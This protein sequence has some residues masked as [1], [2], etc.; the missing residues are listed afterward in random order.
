[1][2]VFACG[3]RR[4]AIVSVLIVLAA[5]APEKTVIPTSTFLTPAE[6]SIA[7]TV[8]ATVTATSG[9]TPSP[10]VEERCERGDDLGRMESNGQV[11]Q[12]VLHVPAAYDPAEP[13]ALVLVFHGAGI[14]AERFIDYSRFSN[15]ADRNGF[16]VVYPEGVHEVWDPSPGSRDVQ[17]I[18][19]LIDHLQKR[20]RIDP[21]RIYASGHSN[22]G[23]MVERLACE[24]ADRLA[25]IGPISGAYQSSGRCSPS[26][27]VP[28][29]AIHGTADTIIPYEGI[30]GWAAGWAARNDC[31]ARPEEIPH[32]VLIH[33]TKWSGCAEGADVILYTIRDLG[34]DW[35]HDLIDMGQTIWEFFEAHPR[36]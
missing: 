24:L 19:D 32:N 31:A 11:R 7:P 30:P 23:G 3:V 26:R 14:G 8:E 34:H 16:L 27:P 20:C 22:G 4:T 17:F 36:A 13:S 25:A 35:T 15:V 33:E 21:N 5:C 1:M 6:T 10:G 28:V 18:R 9:D 29:F 2:N 12:Y